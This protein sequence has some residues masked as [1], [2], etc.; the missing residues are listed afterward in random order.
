MFGTLGTRSFTFVFQEY[1][2]LVVLVHDSAVDAIL[3]EN[4]GKS[5]SSKRTKHINIRYF[6]LQTASNME[7]SILSIAQQMTWSLIFLP[8]LYKEKVP[9]IQEDNHELTRL[10]SP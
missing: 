7:S 5:S 9:K 1:G 8:S 10:K 4:N 6:S 3:L 2:R